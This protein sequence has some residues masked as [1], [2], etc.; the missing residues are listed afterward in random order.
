[1]DKVLAHIIKSSLAYFLLKYIIDKVVRKDKNYT[2]ISKNNQFMY[3]ITAELKSRMFYINFWK[4]ESDYIANLPID[5]RL[6]YGNFKNFGIPLM[7]TYI[8]EKFR[9]M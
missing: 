4:L 2:F 7:Y 3:I 1:M 9:L 5:A 8:E 6:Y